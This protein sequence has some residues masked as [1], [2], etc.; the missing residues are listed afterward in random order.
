MQ[1][2]PP[3]QRR[4]LTSQIT[5]RIIA[6]CD[7][8]QVQI[9]PI[10]HFVSEKNDARRTTAVLIPIVYPLFVRLPHVFLILQS[11]YDDNYSTRSIS[12]P[13]LITHHDQRHHYVLRHVSSRTTNPT[14][15]S[16]CVRSRWGG[17]LIKRTNNYYCIYRTLN[18]TP[19]HLH[20]YHHNTV[21]STKILK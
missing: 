3:W 5:T 16:V 20:S 9:P 21:V 8:S 13:P 12:F 19:K 17:I 2:R 14:A 11:I 15:A 1:Y 6:L 4:I 18:G 10:T 7:R